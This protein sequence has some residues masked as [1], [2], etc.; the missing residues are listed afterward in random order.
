MAEDA[1]EEVKENQLRERAVP[2]KEVGAQ[3]RAWN[4]Y[5]GQGAVGWNQTWL[6][7]SGLDRYGINNRR[8][9]HVL[10]SPSLSTVLVSI[11]RTILKTER[12]HKATTK[13]TKYDVSSFVLSSVLLVMFTR[14]S[15]VSRLTLT[16]Y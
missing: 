11:R 14:S 16:A 1:K 9:C 4:R 12:N 10:L 8:D 5:Q 7:G 2:S 13:M 3:G 15:S 6:R